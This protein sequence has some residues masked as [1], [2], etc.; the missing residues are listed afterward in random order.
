MKNAASAAFFIGNLKPAYCQQK[1]VAISTVVNF[2]IPAHA[3][4]TEK[5]Q[6]FVV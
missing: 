1:T 5:Y 2:V 4:M 6:G 3:G